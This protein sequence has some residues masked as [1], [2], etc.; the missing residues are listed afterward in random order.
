MGI[1]YQNNIDPIDYLNNIN[2]IENNNKNGVGLEGY[3]SQ[4]F[5]IFK[6]DNTFCI[7]EKKTNNMLI[8]Q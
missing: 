1:F 4:L 7:I 6:G 8:L 5:K 2:N 3:I